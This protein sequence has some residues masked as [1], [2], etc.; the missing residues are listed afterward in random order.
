MTTTLP[1]RKRMCYGVSPAK[2]VNHFSQ[3]VAVFAN[4]YCCS[5]QFIADRS[6]N[7]QQTGPLSQLNFFVF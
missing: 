5:K 3:G 2:I 1:Q 6:F 4:K 7:R